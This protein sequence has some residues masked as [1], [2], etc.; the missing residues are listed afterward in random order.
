MNILI[1][2]ASRGIGKAI[3]E[4]FA[5][6][7]YDLYITSQSDIALYKAMEDLQKKYDGVNIK[8]KAF[9]LSKSVEAKKA[10]NWLIDAGIVPDIL[11]N[12]AGTFEPG[13]VF[14]EPEGS[15]ERQMATN[16]FQCLSSH[17]YGFTQNDAT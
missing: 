15:M 8:A 5:G 9:D 3:A 1:S 14:S 13:S 7:G 2:G 17:P 4:I 16:F 12:N 10:G 6:N 11:V